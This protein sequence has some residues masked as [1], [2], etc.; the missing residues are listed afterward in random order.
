[1]ENLVFNIL[2]ACV[3]WLSRLY[4]VLCELTWANRKK[5]RKIV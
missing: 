2:K 3:I 4:R 5:E 1:L